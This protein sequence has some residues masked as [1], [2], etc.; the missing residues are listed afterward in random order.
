MEVTG[1]VVLHDSD[2]QVFTMSELNQ[3]SFLEPQALPY[4]AYSSQTVRYYSDAGQPDSAAYD[5]TYQTKQDE[6]AHAV[7]ELTLV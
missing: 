7:V 3:A 2:L 6:T 4:Q 1:V 5:S